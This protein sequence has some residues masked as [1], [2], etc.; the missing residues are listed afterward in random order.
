MKTIITIPKY[1][2]I[3]NTVASLSGALTDY[4]IVN[5]VEDFVSKAFTV[6]FWIQAS[7]KNTGTILS[8]S[9]T[10]ENSLVIQNPQNIN[11]YVNSH[12]TNPTGIS[13]VNTKDNIPEW[14]YFAL[15][16]DS[17]SGSL[18]LYKDAVLAY[19]TTVSPG[20]PLVP[21]GALVLAQLQ[22]SAG[23]NFSDSFEGRITQLRIWDQV[24]TQQLI[25]QDM[26][27][28]IYN[29][30]G[31]A[32]W[33]LPAIS[34]PFIAISA[35]PNIVNSSPTVMLCGLDAD[36]NFQVSQDG[37]NTWS[38]I[39]LATK[40][41][42]IAVQGN[43]VVWGYWKAGSGN[44]PNIMLS[45]NSGASWTQTT[46][47]GA[48]QLS[49][50]APNVL[51]CIGTANNLFISTN[52]S[53]SWTLV[54]SAT[55]F[56]YID[57]IS[58]TELWMVDTSGGLNHSTNGGSSF[59]SVPTLID[60]ITQV[61]YSN[62]LLMV[63]KKDGNL[64]YSKDAGLTWQDVKAVVMPPISAFTLYNNIVYAV[65]LLGQVIIAPIDMNMILN[66]Q[67]NE[68]YGCYGFDYSGNKNNGKIGLCSTEDSHEK[69]WEVS[70]RIQ[71][72]EFIV[73]LI[74][75]IPALAAQVRRE[76]EEQEKLSLQLPITGK[77]EKE[78]K[79]KHTAKEKKVH[80]PKPKKK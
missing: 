47:G 14:H 13:F 74:D 15:T 30:T 16:W 19:T 20:A 31:L 6:E 48:A 33:Q 71:S 61:C 23:G 60:K 5:P 25:E 27:R 1:D 49:A 38:V 21:G 58:A 24:R 42:G 65:T 3:Y 32:T 56:G 37:G 34:R 26:R 78:V 80:K 67:L 76:L 46:S 55:N 10:G 64:A 62:G 68:G 22:G 7:P 39:T 12:T 43:G 18:L 77:V 2:P 66:W 53:Q 45:N 44:P 63:L 70:T 8:Y 57:A 4:I 69:G 41:N 79:P 75:A 52:N 9:L 73:G 50:P 36:N 11:L 59:T 29:N 35:G 40:L 54:N 72:P 51:F 17:N 28:N